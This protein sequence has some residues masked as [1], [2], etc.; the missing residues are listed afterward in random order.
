[1]KKKI[2]GILGVF[3][4]MIL[5]GYIGINVST[6]KNE[7]PVANIT[8]TN[9]RETNVTETTNVAKTDVEEEV[10]TVDSTMMTIN[11]DVT[12]KVDS[13]TMI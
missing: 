5:V 8:N 9:I 3:G 13:S 10:I 4:I 2:L 7:E 1:M 6:M 11:N 12:S